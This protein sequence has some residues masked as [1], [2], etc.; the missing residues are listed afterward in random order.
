[1]A[2][3]R[4][5]DITVEIPVTSLPDIA[6]WILTKAPE[7]IRQS[8]MAVIKTARELAPKKNHDLE[9]GIVLNPQIE[10]T[11]V[12]GRIMMDVW[13]DPAKNDLFVKYSKKGKRYYYPASQEYGFRVKN[14]A[15]RVDGKYYMKTAGVMNYANN[16]V[17][18]SKAVDDMLEEVQSNV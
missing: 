17:I 10:H 2:R 13:M 11:S 1:M 7:R 18:I 4:V 9:Q 16:E 3:Y 12:V 15:D 5:D 8:A 14:G 6:R